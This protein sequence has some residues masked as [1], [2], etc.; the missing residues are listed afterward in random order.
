[1]ARRVALQ[2][3]P[4]GAIK[5][6]TDSTLLL[7]LEAQKRG[8]ELYHYTP[9]RLSWLSGTLS[10]EAER[11][12]LYADAKKHFEAHESCTLDLRDVDV[13]LL[14]QDPPF[15]MAYI[16][17][18]YMLEQLHPR[19]LVVN[20]PQ[21]VRDYPEKIF[22]T[23]FA[24][25]MPPTLIT[26]D[27]EAIN[28][29]RKEHKDIVL[30]PL[31]GHAGHGVSRLKSTDK[32]FEALLDKAFFDRAEPWIAQKFLPEVKTGDRR[33]VL[34]DGK[35]AGIMGR[36]PAE[37]EF[38]AN[39]RVGGSP[40]KAELTPKQEEICEAVGILLKEKGLLF[41]GLDCIGDWLTEVNFTSPTGLV[42][43][44]KLYNRRLEAEIWDAIESYLP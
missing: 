44:N 37:N 26:A 23:L 29:F 10:A 14:R 7:G 9:D 1:M 34:I 5:P 39:F 15:N 35:V 11:V 2:M 3:D 27:R 24:Q 17:T 6:A 33:I 38:R 32:N 18:T 21:A 31:Y 20:N 12:T 16:S 36:I 13:I 43:M 8:Y 25:Y 22:P 19:P 4:L 42:Q 28:K 41:A 30:K 40:A